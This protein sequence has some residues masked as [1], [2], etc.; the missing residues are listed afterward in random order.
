MKTAAAKPEKRTGDIACDEALF[1]VLRTLRREV[2]DGL[3]VPAYIVF[4]DNTLRHM[5]RT[6]PQNEREMSRIPGV[7]AKKLDDF[8]AKFMDAIVKFLR[9]NPRQVF[10]DSLE[11]AA[12]PPR[13]MKPNAPNPNS[14]NDTAHMSWRMFDAGKDIAAIAKERSLSEGTIGGHLAIAIET[15]LAVD[16]TRIVTAAELDRIR[17]L[18]AAHGTASMRPIFDELGGKLD[19]GRIRIACAILQ[20]GHR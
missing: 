10:A 7:G 2:A 13:A 9:E 11:P 20:R 3:G 16:I 5:A 19:Y 12:A 15:G 4:G 14:L 6:Y 8:G 1:E 18:L 17:P